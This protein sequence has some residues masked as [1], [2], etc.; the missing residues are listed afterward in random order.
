V[1]KEITNNGEVSQRIFPIIIFL[2]RWVAPIAILSMFIKGL[3]E[4]FNK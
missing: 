4:M 1:R 2:L 3:I